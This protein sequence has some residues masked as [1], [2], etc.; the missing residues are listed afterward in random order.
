[1]KFTLNT[2]PLSNAINLGVIN[3]NV[4][5]FNRRSGVVQL[6]ATKKELIINIQSNM[7]VTKII[8][9]GSGDSDVPQILFVDAL[10]LKQLLNTLESNIITLN[11]EEGGLIIKA[12]NSEF[13]LPNMVD[14]AEFRLDE[15][16]AP[17]S[18]NPKSKIEQ[19]KWSFIKDKQMFAVSTAFI[20]PV[21]TKLWVG[22]QGDV[23]A[24]DFDI[25]LFTHSTKS[26]LNNQCLLSDTIVNLLTSLPENALISRVENDYVIEFKS[27]TFSYLTQISP[28]YES[29]PDVGSYESDI[30]LS[31][32]QHPKDFAKIDNIKLSKLLSQASLLA[33]GTDT[34]IDFILKGNKLTVKNN[35]VEGVIELTGSALIDFQL[36]FKLDTLRKIFNNYDTETLNFAPVIAEDEV[37]GIIIWEDDLTTVLAGVEDGI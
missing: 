27:E 26:N 21:Y 31:I 5:N 34:T 1:M 35:N 22:N 28:I 36:T 23:L 16:V 29:D 25:S 14:G 15:P 17:I 11:F 10:L 13:T 12:G 30:I 20:H 33:T 24:G 32:L 2:K 7:I 18:E 37:T 19:M 6:T 9:N 8:L 3:S 4:S